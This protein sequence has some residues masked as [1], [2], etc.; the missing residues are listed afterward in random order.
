M[1]SPPPT[2]GGGDHRPAYSWVSLSEEI[3]AIINIESVSRAKVK[4]KLYGA[5]SGIHFHDDERI[6]SMTSP[7]SGNY[8]KFI[9]QCDIQSHLFGE[10]YIW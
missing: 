8:D 9:K 10:Q 6:I 5:R 1:K 4:W 2:P 7:F 3:N